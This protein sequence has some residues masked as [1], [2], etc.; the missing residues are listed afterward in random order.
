M[1][2]VM[3]GGMV[4]LNAMCSYSERAATV[5]AVFVQCFIFGLFSSLCS[6]VGLLFTYRKRQEHSNLA[7]QG[8]VS[9]H[10]YLPT[11]YIA[12][13]VGSYPPGR[14][15]SLFVQS[16]S[17]PAV[18]PSRPT[19]ALSEADQRVPAEGPES[20]LHCCTHCTHPLSCTCG[21]LAP[22]N[23]IEVAPPLP[24]PLSPNWLQN[25][26]PFFPIPHIAAPA[27]SNSNSRW[28]RVHVPSPSQPFLSPQN[29]NRD[30]DF[31]CL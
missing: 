1:V 9:T 8:S 16:R 7:R 22:I 10:L 28:P 2:D 25:L 20:P 27:T 14:E 29:Q 21:G 6:Q 17:F 24:K 13:V 19:Y 15:W 12:P 11:L 4:D 5:R 30:L 26:S 3:A 31:A 18:M 23:E